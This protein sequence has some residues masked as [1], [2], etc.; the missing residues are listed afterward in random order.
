MISDRLL[1]IV[2]CPE[3]AGALAGAPTDLTCQA[4]GRRY[5]SSTDFLDLRPQEPFAEKT[6]Y[7]DDAL[8]ADG[9]HARVSPPLLSAGVRHGMLRRFLRP[10]HGDVIADLGCGSGRELL[11]NAEAGAYLVGV[12][13]APFFAAE[14]RAQ[15][16]LVVGDLRRLPVADGAFT[17]AF[18]LDVWEHLSRDGLDQVLRETARVVAPGGQVFVYSHVRKNSRLALGLR[19]INRLA[20]LLDR[21]G[22]IDLAQER[23]RKSDH[24]NP[25]ADLDDLR[26]VTAAAGFRIANIRY[27]TPLIGGFVE[28]IL[29]RL[30]ERALGRREKAPRAAAPSTSEPDA[31]R[32][33]TDAAGEP[34]DAAARVARARAKARLARHGPLYYTLVAVTW[35]MKLDVVLFGRVPSGPFFALLVKDGS[36]DRP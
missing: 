16:D 35:L 31:G 8:H 9:R 26:R 18:A 11:W 7:L 27:Y 21:V 24:L 36:D 23:L 17:K 34:P 19:G 32:Q 10:G 20:R 13:V 33:A 29:A 30:A 5:G 15:V 4:C 1:S 12:D 2:R 6:K 28:N 22:A 3:C 25:L 14:T